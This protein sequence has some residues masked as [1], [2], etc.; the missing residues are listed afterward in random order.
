MQAPGL[1][2]V[3]VGARKDSETYVRNKK[4]ACAEVG[5]ESFGTD[6]PE[7]ASQD[8]VLKAVAD[9]N[10]NQDINGI[11]VQLPLPEHMDAQVILDAIDLAKDVDGFHPQN[12]GSLALRG[13]QPT[14]VSCTPKGCMELLKRAGVD[15]SV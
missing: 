10:A 12:V 7:S 8:E 14:F 1:A 13:R 9:Y 2:V 11:L 4:K 6:L 15:P 3:L 5:F